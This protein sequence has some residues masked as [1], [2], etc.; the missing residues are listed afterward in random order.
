VNYSVTLCRIIR[1]NPL[2]SLGGALQKPTHPFR[3]TADRW[4]GKGEKTYRT[5]QI[6][7]FS[8]VSHSAEAIGATV[9]RLAE[10][11]NL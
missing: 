9:S 3:S 11:K 7:A 4:L 6:S 10:F 2:S 5:L 8:D 1:P